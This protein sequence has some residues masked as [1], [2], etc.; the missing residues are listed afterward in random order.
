MTHQWY[1]SKNDGQ[2]GPVSAEQLKQLAA[3]GDLQPTDLVWKEGMSQWTESR[4]IKGLLPPAR[5][6]GSQTPPPVPTAATFAPPLVSTVPTIQT[7]T[8]DSSDS[9][10][11][12]ALWNPQAAGLWS[13]LFTWAFGAFLLA[14]NW[15]ALGNEARAKRCMFW[16]YGYF[17]LIPAF[18]V[19]YYLMKRAAAT[20]DLAEHSSY[21]VLSQATWSSTQWFLGFLAALLIPMFIWAFLEVNPQAKFVKE[22]FGDQYPRKRWLAPLVIAA[23][24]IYVVPILAGAIV[25]G[26]IG[27]VNS[28]KRLVFNNGELLYMPPITEVEA[29]R[30]GKFLVTGGFFNGDGKTVEIT[31][32]GSVYQFRMVV[33]AGMDK[34]EKYAAICKALCGEISRGVF[35]GAPVE[36]HL[37]DE[38]LQKIRVVSLNGEKGASNPLPVIP[39]VVS[40]ILGTWVEQ[41]GSGEVR[42]VF[43]D[44]GGLLIEDKEPVGLKYEFRQNDKVVRIRPFDDTNGS[45]I[46]GSITS[47]GRLKLKG[48]DGKDHYLSHESNRTTGRSGLTP[49]A[50]TSMASRKMLSMNQLKNIGLAMHNYHTANGTFPP[51]YKADEN[52]N[53][54]LSWRV[55]ILPYLEEA[56]LYKQFHLDEPWDSEHN[57]PLIARM[58]TVYKN[59]GSKIADEGRTNYLTVRGE[60]TVFPGRESVTFK[61]IS[62]GSSNTIMLVDASDRKAVIWA[63]PDD[64]EYDERIP[65]NESLGLWPDSFA[66]GMADGSVRSLPL[67]IDPKILKA[68][69]TRNGGENVE[70]EYLNR[71]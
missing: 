71:N 66:V 33:K 11:A 46:E 8:S 47:D 50:A 51:A 42:F 16:F 10:D 45:F 6:T 35:D 18:A 2:Q 17:P 32:S 49:A 29:Q 41:T 28:E 62:D 63:K 39:S 24:L 3:S 9:G 4:N 25:G 53:P 67:S 59:P 38:R 60:N 64:F 36:V 27:A 52:G 14:K 43:N 31:Q 68:L 57:K 40:G 7:T 34:D 69:F 55:L 56:D 37:C 23:G 15:R 21:A 61:A 20:A 26:V 65:L 22:H 12:P 54:L 58:P 70:A 13:V 1:Y 19:L 48:P 5:A 44:S 30:L